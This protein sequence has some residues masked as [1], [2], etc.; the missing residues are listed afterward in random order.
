MTNE[1]KVTVGCRI[2]TELKDELIQLCYENNYDSLSQ[3]IAYLLEKNIKNVT[4]SKLSYED[5]YLIRKSI[6]REQSALLETLNNQFKRE[7]KSIIEQAYLKALPK[8]ANK[9]FK[10]YS[11]DNFTKED[12]EKCIYEF[13]RVKIN[14]DDTDLIEIIR[15][16][17][18]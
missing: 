15:K 16:R 14:E 2:K 7:F 12:M 17:L 8:A 3:F 1:P 11:T 13:L 4:N 18:K 5:E 10:T 9:L 6:R